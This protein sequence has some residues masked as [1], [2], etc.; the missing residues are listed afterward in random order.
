MNEMEKTMKEKQFKGFVSS[1]LV[2]FMEQYKLEKVQ[3]ED[4]NGNK[5]KITK[6]KN[7]FL[8]VETTIKETM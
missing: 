6:D 4:G 1:T 2:N 5:A 3:I 8:K 7:G